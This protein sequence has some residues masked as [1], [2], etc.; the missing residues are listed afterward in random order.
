MP[1]Y[2]ERKLGPDT[3]LASYRIYH[4][5]LFKSQQYTVTIR[6]NTVSFL[7]KKTGEEIVVDPKKE[8]YGLH[9]KNPHFHSKN[10]IL[11]INRGG[12]TI[13]L[14]GHGP[15]CKALKKWWLQWS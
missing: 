4:R 5:R 3:P 13:G 12:E 9:L 7:N 11:L 1:V 2:M 10:N 8:D 6:R 14:T 15:V